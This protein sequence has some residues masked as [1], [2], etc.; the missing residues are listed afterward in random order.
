VVTD[1]AIDALHAQALATP[2][3]TPSQTFI[4]PWD[5]TIARVGEE[6]TPLAQRDAT[7]VV[8]PSASWENPGDDDAMIGWARGFRENIRCFASAGIY[9]DFIGDEGAERV[10]AA[11]GNQKYARL[12]AVK[13]HDDPT[14]LLRGNHNIKPHA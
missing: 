14:S 10:Q 1:E 4:V 9:L 8:N 6:E 12:A 13:A 3:P 5:G 11:F 2:S 7:W